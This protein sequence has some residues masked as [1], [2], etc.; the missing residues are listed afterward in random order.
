MMKTCLEILIFWITLKNYV[1]SLLNSFFFKFGGLD[2]I[3]ARAHWPLCST[4]CG[5]A[6]WRRHVCYV[7]KR[8]VCGED[9][10]QPVA[11]LGHKLQCA[12]Q[13]LK[14]MLSYGNKYPRHNARPHVVE[15]SGQCARDLS[16]F[17]YQTMLGKMKRRI[18][19]SNKPLEQ[20]CKRLSEGA[21]AFK[22][23]EHV[24]R[25]R[26]IPGKMKDSC[27]MLRNRDIMLVI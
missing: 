7:C 1:Y 23:D 4:T 2:S 18:R 24:N 11:H 19:S 15:Q 10:P 20:S 16:A 22:V 25:Y 14:I 5:R 21:F 8:S 9:E 26:I 27:V 3:R 12:R 17:P 6:L 13:S